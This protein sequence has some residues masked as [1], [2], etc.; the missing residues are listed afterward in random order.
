MRKQLS[1]VLLA[2]FAAFAAHG[3][4]ITFVSPQAGG[5]AMGP[6][7]IEIATDVTGVDRVEFHV[8]GKL[9][10]VARQAPWRIAYDFGTSLA[11]HRVTAKVFSNRYQTVQ[12]AEVLTAAITAGEIHDVDVVEVPLRVR[13][14]KTVVAKDLSVRE[15]GV[16]QTIREI[17]PTRGPAHFAFVI[18]RSLSMGDGRLEAALRAVD[19]GRKLL[20]PDD[21]VS[22]ALFNHQVM[23]SRTIRRGEQLSE[24]FGAIEPSGGTSLRDAMA[25]VATGQRMYVIAITDGGDRNSE[26]NE[27]EALRRVSGTKMIVGGVVLGTRSDFVER[28][29]KNT[30][31]RII[32][33]KGAATIEAAVRELISDIN[34]RYFLVYQSQ[35]TKEG[36]RSIDIRGAARGVQV[37]NAR[38]GYFAE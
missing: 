21:T 17:K 12:S 7:P 5:Q 14:A 35:G 36:W 23:K 3:A 28:A 34:S 22:V 37:V 1:A 27:E 6:L 10:G 18:D 30:G 19:A 38:K 25:A 32:R 24:L 11:G 16:A 31:G 2:A 4:T 20:R 13:A 29:S 15:N 26:L 8:D 9:A 33:A